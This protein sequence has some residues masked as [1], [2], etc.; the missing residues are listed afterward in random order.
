MLWTAHTHW[1]FYIYIH[2]SPKTHPC[3][4]QHYSLIIY[5]SLQA[6][7]IYHFVLFTWNYVE[8]V[9]LRVTQVVVLVRKQ[10]GWAAHWLMLQQPW[11][12]SLKQQTTSPLSSYR[13][14]GL[15][16]L[17]SSTSRRR[18]DVLILEECAAAEPS[19]QHC[20]TLQTARVDYPDVQIKQLWISLHV[21][22]MQSR[23]NVSTV[24]KHIS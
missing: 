7:R 11:C 12:L 17:T 22:W 14:D 3:V 2:N 19:L 18:T 24:S 8:R 21:W 13:E 6:C 10:S 9:A 23:K 1:S 5:F 16:V 4:F 20:E 15:T